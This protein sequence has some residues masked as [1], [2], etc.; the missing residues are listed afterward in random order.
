ML[1][2]SISFRYKYAVGDTQMNRVSLGFAG[3]RD[4]IATETNRDGQGM[5]Q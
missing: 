4:P 2:E 1:A 5:D 3:R